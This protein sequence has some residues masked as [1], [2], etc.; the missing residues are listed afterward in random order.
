M[1]WRLFAGT[2]GYWCCHGLAWNHLGEELESVCGRVG[3]AVVSPVLHVELVKGEMFVIQMERDSA[4]SGIHEPG[5]QKRVGLKDDIS[6]LQ[7]DLMF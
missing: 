6:T 4:R 7:L 3:V 5:A 2:C 1:R